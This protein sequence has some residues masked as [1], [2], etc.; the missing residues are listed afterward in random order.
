MTK[1][2]FIGQVS[3]FVDLPDK[4]KQ[5]I[6]IGS[7]CVVSLEG[8]ALDGYIPIEPRSTVSPLKRLYKSN[9]GKVYSL[10]KDDVLISCPKNMQF[11]YANDAYLNWGYQTKQ[12]TVLFGGITYPDKT[13]LQI[14]VFNQGD[15]IFVDERELD[16]SDTGFYVDS[17]VS[18]VDEFRGRFE[19]ARFCYVSP[20][21]DLSSAFIDIEQI[22]EVQIF[23]KLTYRKLGYKE[24]GRANDLLAPFA[25]IAISVCVLGWYLFKGW[26]SYTDAITAYHTAMSDPIVKQDGGIGGSYVDTM[27]QQRFFMLTPRYQTELIGHSTRLVNAVIKIPSARIISLRTSSPSAS[28][29][30][31]AS[32]EDGVPKTSKDSPSDIRIVLSVPKT[33]RKALEQGKEMLDVI[34]AHSGLSLHMAEQGQ[35][36]RDADKDRQFTFEG[37]LPLF[38]PAKTK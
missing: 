3:D 36:W 16:G 5:A 22:P 6:L 29:G 37:M 33:S 31:A 23:K 35:G 21:G 10:L 34:T 17:I 11:A 8:I 14:Y 20:L 30:I 15:L 4:A 26:M 32:A 38:D 12:K 13:F 19:D 28:L 1:T 9:P 24:T 2:I 27:Q 7:A 25:I 18:I